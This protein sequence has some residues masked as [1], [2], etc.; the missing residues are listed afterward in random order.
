LNAFWDHG[1]VEVRF[2]GHVLAEDL[3][4]K[5]PAAANIEDHKRSEETLTARRR[6]SVRT[7]AEKL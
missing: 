4:M 6:W 7:L 2:A 3:T 1:N 5:K